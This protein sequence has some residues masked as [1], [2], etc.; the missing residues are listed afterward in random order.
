MSV[1]IVN[2][3]KNDEESINAYEYILLNSHLFN[4]DYIP[5]LDKAKSDEEH[6]ADDEV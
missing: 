3:R 4:P 1:D 6:D 5:V 2:N